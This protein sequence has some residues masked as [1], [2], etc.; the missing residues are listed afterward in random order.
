MVE[1]VSKNELE[2]R[3][4]A[5]E[6]ARCAWPSDRKGAHGMMKCF[7]NIKVSNG[8]ADFGKPKAYQKLKVGGF[9]Q[10]EEGEIEEDPID[11][12]EIENEDEEEVQQTSDGELPTEDSS[13]DIA[14]D[15]WNQQESSSD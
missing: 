5:K 13:E 2:R 1:G 6:C 3:K 14:E 10:Q 15:W 11:E 7:Q 8:T 4:A 12:Y 9:D